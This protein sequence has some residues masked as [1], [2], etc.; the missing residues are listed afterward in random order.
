MCWA[1]NMYSAPSFPG[2]T[3]TSC[4]EGRAILIGAFAPRSQS[5]AARHSGK[6]LP[7]H[8]GRA[9]W[10]IVRKQAGNGEILTGRHALF[11]RG[12]RVEIRAGGH[13]A[14]GIEVQA[15]AEPQYGLGVVLTV[16]IELAVAGRYKEFIA[17]RCADDLWSSWI[18]HSSSTDHDKAA[19]LPPPPRNP[20]PEL[21]GG[22]PRSPSRFP[23]SARPRDRARRSSR[24]K[25]DCPERFR[26][27][28]TYPRP[29]VSPPAAARAARDKD[30]GAL[31]A[32]M[33][34]SMA[35]FCASSW[36]MANSS[37][38]H[39]AGRKVDNRH[40]VPP[41]HVPLRRLVREHQVITSTS[42][43]RQQA[44]TLTLGT[45]QRNRRNDLPGLGL[46]R[47]ESPVG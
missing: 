16:E 47:N 43:R 29:V 27:T 2:C 36:S 32:T 10:R 13:V 45:R 34:L 40:Q 5:F 38:G 37:S 15:L 4:P 31:N 12:E 39:G 23:R 3:I 30:V 26:T 28:R 35:G 14:C 8:L 6:I 41:P 18:P 17:I 46:H 9:K 44:G 25:V 33:P 22:L 11:G 21:S 42:G 1:S 7:S 24:A 20:S 19:S